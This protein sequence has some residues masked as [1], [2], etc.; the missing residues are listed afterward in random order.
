MCPEK[1]NEAVMGL[2]HKS[3]M[4]WL[5]ELGLFSL[6]K[7]KLRGKHIALYNCL[8]VVKWVSASS[9]R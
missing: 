2:E 9:P 7:R 8:K 1:G 4:E 6:E 3:Y 5:G